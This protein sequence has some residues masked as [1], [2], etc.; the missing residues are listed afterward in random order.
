M[1][2]HAAWLATVAMTV[3][4]LPLE[5]G[6]RGY[7]FLPLA[8]AFAHLVELVALDVG[9]TLV[10]WSG[11]MDRIVTD[12][13]E[14][15]PEYFP[16]VPR[17]FEK[18]HA[19]VRRDVGAAGVAKR[20]LFAWSLATGRRV[21]GSGVRPPGRLDRARLAVADRL[22]LAKV[23]QALGGRIKF[24][25]TGAAPIAPE[26]LEFFQAIGV[27][28][29]ESY[30][31]TESPAITLNTPAATRIGSVGKPL[32][33]MDVRIAGDGEI[34]LRGPNLLRGYYR[35]DTSTAA[36]LRDGWLHT[37]DVG[38]QDADGYVYITGRK[39]ELI[40]TATGKNLAPVEMENWLR[41][42]PGIAHA[43]LCGDRRPYVTALLALDP[44]AAPAGD[45][46]GQALAQQA[47]DA[48]NA[49]VSRAVQ[50]KRFAI[51]PG[52]LSQDAGELTPTLKVKRAVVYERYA[53]LIDTLYG[54]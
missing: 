41:Q 10:L 53:D 46:A 54:V 11:D 36:T 7:L 4:G 15:R 49:R 22:V 2:D 44:E 48:V 1:L 5:P 13:A 8:H 40:I 38:R 21:R 31:M 12:L 47:V 6:E 34:L 19:V 50:I 24:C 52:E 9:G 28:V 3:R 45:G 29:L 25:V 30:G 16:S 18:F 17:L 23:R 14:T 42:Q 37:G 35:D 51:L 26:I 43:V 32:H 27:P 39:K 20:T 33:G